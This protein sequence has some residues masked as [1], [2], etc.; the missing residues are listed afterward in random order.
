MQT[1]AI[2]GTGLIGASFGLAV[3]AAG[4]RGRIIGVSSPGA[5]RDALA[6]GAIDAA[7]C[8]EDAAAECDLAYLAQPIRRIISTLEAVGPRFRPGCIVTDAGSTKAEICAAARTHVAHARFIGGHPLAGKE[9]RGALEADAALFR[10]RTY[11]LTG[12]PPAELLHW[13]KAIGA[14]PVVMT[15]EEHDRVIAFTSHL[16]QLIS[17]AL[18]CAV[19]G[20]DLRISGPGLADMLRLAGSSWEIWED[21]LRTNTAPVAAA[22]D[23]YIARL[24][25]VRSALPDLKAEF[26]QANAVPRRRR[27]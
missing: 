8:A 13:I 22:L 1:I 9:T 26:E 7:A 2:F 15:A 10:N 17:T 24:Q 11:V 6:C 19:S 4:Y 5:I 27:G 21:I 25:R 3:R 18:A 23:S 12:E 14:V 20:E 16:P